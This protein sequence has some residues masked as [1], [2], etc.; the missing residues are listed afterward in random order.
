MTVE[1]TNPGEDDCHTKLRICRI[2]SSKSDEIR[3]FVRFPLSCLDI[4]C[5]TVS[6]KSPVAYYFFAFAYVL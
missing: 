3:W 4:F 6:L 1:K 2:N 5:M